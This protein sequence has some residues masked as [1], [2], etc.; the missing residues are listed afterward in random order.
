[1]MSILLRGLL[2]DMDGVLVDSTPAVA[3][4]WTRWALQHNMDPDYVVQFAHGRTSLTSIQELLP[5]ASPEAHL[6]EDRWMERAEIEDVADVVALPGAKELLATVPPAQIAVVTSATRPLAEV[7]LRAAGLWPQVAQLVTASDVQRGKPDP[8]PYLKGA[9][10]I[11]L[12]PQDC[13]VIEDAPSGT[14]SGKAAGTHVLAVRTTTADEPLLAAGADWI[15]N[16]C[17]SLRISTLP[18]LGQIALEFSPSE[19]PRLPKMR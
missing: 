14:R 4:V 12:A 18:D 10:A 8:E 1:M 7:R 2:V 13:V 17:A 6:E 15:V 9:A 16:D 5:H 19:P 3:R 11:H